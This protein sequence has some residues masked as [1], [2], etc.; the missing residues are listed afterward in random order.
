[1]NTIHPNLKFTPTHEV[2]RTINF[3]DLT[4]TIHDSTFDINIYRKPTNTD[5]T[6]NYYSNHPLEHKRAAY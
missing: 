5:T 4:I 6:I 3:L 2:N 1:M